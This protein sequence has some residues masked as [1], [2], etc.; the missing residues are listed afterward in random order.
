MVVTLLANAGEILKGEL[1]YEMLHSMLE[2]INNDLNGVVQNEK[3]ELIKLFEI[4]E[5]KGV[6]AEKAI[7]KHTER[8]TS[9]TNTALF[10]SRAPG[11]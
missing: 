11:R 6:P 4:C 3:N 2:K 5:E 10:H 7:V 8:V 1:T 9:Y